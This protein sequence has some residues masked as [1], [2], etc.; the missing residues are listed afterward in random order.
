MNKVKNMIE[1]IR[2]FFKNNV[3][4]VVLTLF[5]LQLGI[6]IWITPNRYDSEFFIK[7]MSEMSVLDFINL[8]Y[9][10]WTSRIIIEFFVCTILPR[11]SLVWALLNTIMMTILGYS[12]FKIFVKDDDKKMTWMSLAFISIYPL[13]K[14]ATCDWGAGSM[15]YTWP[16]A[17]L[18]FSAISIKKIFDGEKISKYM[19]LLYSIALIFACN[20]EQACGIAFGIYLI[21]LVLAFLKNN[22]KVH[23]FLVV[24]FIITILSLIFIITCPGNNARKLDEIKT[25]YVDFEMLSIFDKVSLGLTA[26]VNNLLIE[27]NVVFLV[28]SIL[29]A[30]YIFAKH[31]NKLYRVI[32]L[33]P[34]VFGLVFGVFKE[35]AYELFP[36]LGILIE[37]MGQEHIMLT[38]VNYIDF[39]NFL[40]LVIAF[41]V[42]GSMALN[43]LLIFKNLK[44]NVAIVIYA[45]GV[46]SRVIMG[47]SPTVFASTDRTFLFFDFALIIICILIWQEFLKLTD[48]SQVKTRNRLQTCIVTLASLQYLHTLVYTL[49][50]QI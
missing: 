37:M 33:I 9:N 47:F 10:T 43:I 31:K 30:M 15:N 35:F 2:K 19:Y 45:A 46:M 27:S 28:F 41:V 23:P 39:V 20:Q 17:M 44:S 4:I 49:I 12:I 25:Y 29:S 3:R 22:K 18:M 16:L 14:I 34:V 36:Y 6:S 21:F 13:N 42:L 5:L 7:Q 26:T 48:K 50:S 1:V 24:Q 8:R 38:P 11:Y 40:P 32:A